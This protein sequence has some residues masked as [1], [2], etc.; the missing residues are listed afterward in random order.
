METIFPLEANQKVKIDLRSSGHCQR[1]I[2]A[3]AYIAGPVESVVVC[4]INGHILPGPCSVVS[5]GR[6]RKVPKAR[7]ESLYQQ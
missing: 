1:P 7:S 2:R 3:G 6:G 5:A 4:I